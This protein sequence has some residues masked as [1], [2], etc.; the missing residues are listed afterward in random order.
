M[1]LQKIK[2]GVPRLKAPK[3]EFYLLTPDGRRPHYKGTQLNTF[4]HAGQEMPPILRELCEKLNRDLG[5][6][7]DDRFNHCLIICNEQSGIGP[8][9]HC[10]PPHADKIQKGFFVD[11]SL[12][13]LGYSR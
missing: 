1:S 3:A 5:L 8:N 13:R 4:D 10:A 12:S 11:I 2:G 7:G 6:T 9:A